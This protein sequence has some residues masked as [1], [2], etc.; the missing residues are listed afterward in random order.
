MKLPYIL[1]CPKPGECGEPASFDE[2]VFF[3]LLILGISYA[4]Y[5]LVGKYFKSNDQRD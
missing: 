2:I 5:F 1:P 3:A 4:I